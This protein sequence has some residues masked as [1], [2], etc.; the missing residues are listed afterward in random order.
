MRAKRQQ[1][2][3]CHF[4]KQSLAARLLLTIL[5]L[6]GLAGPALAVDRIWTGLGNNNNWSE[7]ANWSNDS[8]PGPGDRAIFNA[9][10]TKD[11]V[12]DVDFSIQAMTIEAGYTG[13]ITQGASA[14]TLVNGLYSQ[15]DGHFVGGSGPISFSN[16]FILSGGTFT[17]SSGS[18]S[19]NASF[20][21]TGGNWEANG[22][23]VAFV[24]NFD[25]NIIVGEPGTIEFH[26]MVVNLGDN[27]T[28]IQ[29]SVGTTIV[30]NGTLTFISG[31]LSGSGILEARAG[32]LIPANH[33]SIEGG[34]LR[35]AGEAVRTIVIP[36]G[37]QLSNL[38][39]NAPNTTVTT[40][41]SGL[42][43]LGSVQL[44]NAAE[45]SNAAADLE[46]RPGRTW[47]QS[48][49]I[50]SAGSGQLDFRSL[51]T[52]SG[53]SFDA[54]GVA[55]SVGGTFTLS[56]GDFTASSGTTSFHAAFSQTGGA[57]DAN[58]GTVRFL[59]TFD[60]NISISDPGLIE[61]NDMEVNLGDNLNRLSPV[62]G[63]TI[64]VNG[65]LAFVSGQLTGSGVLEARG[66]VLIPANHTS[67]EGGFL[68][69]AGDA[70]RTISIPSGAQLSNLE[71]NAPN[72]TVTT[73][74]SG[75]VTL[76]SIQL[77]NAAE[78]TNAAADLEVRPGRTWVQS[79]G[80]FTAGSGGL[81][82]GSTYSHAGGTF[83][84]SGSDVSITGNFTLSGGDYTASSGITA[85][86]ASFSHSG[87]SWNHNGGTVLFNGPS[88]YQISVI[89]DT[90]FN[91]FQ[92][93]KPNPLTI[94]GDSLVVVRGETAL[95]SGTLGASGGSTFPG[96]LEVHGDLIIGEELSG[97]TANFRFAGDSDQSYVNLGGINPTGVWT[98]AKPGGSLLLQSDLDL[99]NGFFGQA[100]NLIQ[101]TITT[102]QFT[103]L[104]GPRQV[105]RSAG[106]IVGNLQRRITATGNH[107]YP[108]GTSSGYAPVNVNVTA[109]LQNPSE[110]RAGPIGTPHPRLDP[111]SSLGAHWQLTEFGNIVANVTLN[112]LQGDVAGDESAYRLLAISEDTLHVFVPPQVTINTTGNVVVA[113]DIAEFSEWALAE[114]AQPV[115]IAPADA[116]VPPEV[117][118]EFSALAGYPPYV[119]EL[120]DNNS[121]A[122]FDP[123][124]RVYTAGTNLGAID[125]VR[126][127]DAFGFVSESA[128]TV[129]VIPTRA[130]ITIQPGDA[131]AGE[132]IAPAIRVEL[133]DDDGRLAALSTA[134]IS[135]AFADNP[136]NGTLSG[137]STRNAVAGVALFDDLSIDRAAEAYTLSAESV[138][139]EQDVSSEFTISP[140]VATR[141]AFAVQPSDTLL[142]QVITPAVT[143]RIEDDFGNLVS[144]ASDAISIALEANPSGAEL[145]G[146]LTRVASQGL[147][148]FTDL[149]LNVSGSGFTLMAD[150][151]DLASTESN[152]FDIINPFTVTNTNDSGPG[153]L[154][155]AIDA[156]NAS[157][158]L[159][160]ISFNI[161]GS[162]P[163]TIALAATLPALIAPI[164]VDAT[165]QPGYSGTPIVF[166]DGTKL[167]PSQS[168]GFQING[169]NSLIAGFSVFGF[170]TG[171]EINGDGNVIRA[172]HIG[173]DTS[174]NGNVPLH[175]TGVAIAGKFNHVGGSSTEDRNVISGNNEAVR[176]TFD[177]TRYFG[178]IIEGNFIGTDPAGLL[179]VPNRVGIR[180]FS[181]MEKGPIRNQI[182]GNIIAG[183]EFVAIEDAHNVVITENRIGLNAAGE[184]IA[185]NGQ[186]G[187]LV[188]LVPTEQR[189]TLIIRNEIHVNPQVPFRGINTNRSLSPRRNQ[190]GSA[191]NKPRLT[192]ATSTASSL[193]ITGSLYAQ[194]NKNY[195]IEFFASTE[196]GSVKHGPG[197][198]LLG[199]LDIAVGASGLA[200][201]MT[202]LPV[203]LD[204]GTII[205]ATS[206][207]IE[208]GAT[209]EFSACTTA[210]S[211][212]HD[213][214]GSVLDTQ[215]QSAGRMTLRSPELN[216]S[217]LTKADG[218]YRFNWIG[219]GADFS[220]IPSGPEGVQF[221]PSSRSY[222]G[223]SGDLDGQDFL[224]TRSSR[225]NGQIHAP[226]ISGAFPLG[227]IEIILTGPAGA[228][229]VTTL[230]GFYEFA[231]LT[232]G[233]YT[234]TP[235]SPQVA[236]L[237]PSRSIEISG[238]GTTAQA[239][240]D[241]IVP[242]PDPGRIAIRR[243]SS[244]TLHNADGSGLSMPLPGTRGQTV[245]M[246][247]DGSMLAW[248][249]FLEDFGVSGAR[250]LVVARHDGSGRRTIAG[251][252]VLTTARMLFP[253]WSPDGSQ[254]AHVSLPRTI[255][256]RD[257][258]SGALIRQFQVSFHEI[259]ELQWGAHDRLVFTARPNG[260]L[261][262]SGI[263]SISPS[264]TG[265]AAIAFNPG[266]FNF[267][268]PRVSP[269]GNKVLFSRRSSTSGPFSFIAGGILG[270]GNTSIM[271]ANTDGT[272]AIVLP[273]PP[274]RYD[275]IG[276]SPSGARI[277]VSI[278][279]GSGKAIFRIF[280]PATGLFD[281]SATVAQG[282]LAWG[283]S[284]RVQTPT[285]INVSV[286]TGAATLAFTEVSLAGATSA[287]PIAPGSVGELPAGFAAGKFGAWEVTSTATV[288]S[289]IETCFELTE[290]DGTQ[291]LFNKVNVFHKESDLMINRTSS[292]DFASKT[293]CATT[294]S[295]SPFVLAEEIDD[296]LPAIT[297][298]VV[299]NQNLPMAGVPVALTGTE[300]HTILTDSDGLFS[301]VNLT[302]NGNY[303][304]RPS[305]LGHLFSDYRVNFI[306]MVEQDTVVFTGTA[307]SFSISGRV[308]D[309]DDNGIAGVELVV[310]GDAADLRISDA[311]GYF[312]FENLP[313]D[314]RYSIRS[315]SEQFEIFPEALELEP[316]VGD[317]DGLELLVLP[318]PAADPIFSDRFQG[319]R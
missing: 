195:R 264:G 107:E 128:M 4:V 274:D 51:F 110:L 165:T 215:G 33:R 185:D 209:S 189:A 92:L 47:T 135:L 119:F 179:A 72:T 98:I 205:T 61:F 318:L 228:Q 181:L 292:H 251:G 267:A 94:L 12:I 25:I 241:A 308:V 260:T 26:D 159:E 284:A 299:D 91:H 183:N 111:A 278:P 304:V 166:L 227:D 281:S 203:T 200:P 13:T 233:N 73:S 317:V 242:E 207:D 142:Q 16:T 148:A 315:F 216:R 302:E 32:V 123:Q 217:V 114:P 262:P 27:L 67:I 76:G 58:A 161:P 295:L 138:G 144:E 286:K 129:D 240:F 182:R 59:A 168:I 294:D 245:A 84:G 24:S 130:V 62:L 220:L 56:G 277:G 124:T 221:S 175:R 43:T 180:V 296:T 246:S 171:I 122:G 147:A 96:T 15:A 64:V 109:L 134:A 10:S 236:F 232:P 218:S 272:N 310:E 53:G 118:I 79:G 291:A 297:G 253:A 140:A 285:G 108:L 300:L 160:T 88:F 77:L 48:G 196:C 211:A 29:P 307:A 125:V 38:E 169:D 55:M 150:G 104:T 52:L 224:V 115:S 152:P 146:T 66:E 120:I 28:R 268:R 156:A 90:E 254:I 105:Q 158:E 290:F 187:I 20:N 57:W 261:A 305:Q 127:S 288:S 210:Q 234:V 229:A 22:G 283:P 23:T 126:V 97:G 248:D 101:G 6:I 81:A 301:F 1:T 225:I 199:E 194:P 214:S 231:N 258:S 42:V 212:F 7:P 270:T 157:P 50:F 239:N 11:A 9:T 139:L 222:T 102:G 213:L 145:S 316:L 106:H 177:A 137:T 113:N 243:D 193:E 219:A 45:F 151:V 204:P 117:E 18:T 14:L 201:I 75:L 282:H 250:V 39:I 78:F 184:P 153:S 247:A 30:V 162:G 49:G 87:G 303:N 311:N 95:L 89:E 170:Q 263:F 167:A 83:S 36:S 252:S 309:L 163:H 306:D 276:W 99:S 8:V 133:Q 238:S 298:L 206:T 100:L 223:F 141:L 172:N 93:N 188:R 271:L 65:A 5:L 132:L 280:D 244:F 17:A 71:I 143:V 80:N 174:G 198:V 237:P 131:I 176:I 31:Q 197:E 82:F 116:T 313:A 190:S 279:D 37:A 192:E 314:G 287:L 21:Q 63:T 164:Q 208:A 41:G 35:F 259:A 60:I 68:R 86:G 256:I 19:F 155:L 269:D 235:Q 44:I 255:M 46:V 273:I 34:F 266:N 136:G 178:N 3:A 293:V 149:Q 40:S 74:G 312:S 191:A 173:I 154:R 257:V 249:E 202:A 54:G 289:P 186:G 319:G 265:L 226:L 2:M 112:Y 85:F 70:V 103:V 230:F 121:G 69:L 275:Q